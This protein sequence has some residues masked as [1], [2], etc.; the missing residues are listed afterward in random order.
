[1]W[2]FAF[3]ALF[4]IV[5][6]LGFDTAHIKFVAEG[7][8]QNDCFSTYTIIKL[9]LTSLMIVLSV[10]ALII[11]VCNGSMN[12][13]AVG[14]VAI[15]IMFCAVLDI[16]SIFITTFDARL[17]SGKN[18]I[19][20]IA[21][22]TI[23][24]ALLI[25][26]A[27]KQVSADVLST[28]YLV[29]IIVT[30]FLA[31]IL[32]KNVGL[33]LTRPTMFREYATFAAPL[34]L[35][36]LVLASIDSLDRVLIGFSGNPLEVGYYA[37]AM[38]AVVA[39]VSLGS[40]MNNVILPQL[41]S[42][43]MTGSKSKT[44]G[45][46]W[47]SQKY[48]MIMLLPMT[49]ILIVHGG[50]IASVLFGSD[51]HKAGLILSILSVMMT[52]KI[53]SGILSQVLYASNNVKLHTKASVIYG[54][55][56]ILMYFLFIPGYSP[57]PWSEGIGAALAIS[58]GSV[59]YILLLTYYVKQSA[60]VR[61]YSKMWKHIL[62]FSITITVMI[63]SLYCFEGAGLLW[64]AAMSLLGIGIHL[65]VLFITGEFRKSDVEFLLRAM[66]PKEIY[67]SL[68]DELH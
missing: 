67:E 28:S 44:E 56:V 25:I 23:R 45:L 68:E 36:S 12:A 29:S 11:S 18:S 10:T 40:S 6:G 41:S 51:F 58:I 38:G 60:G 33:K 53:M 46:V 17:E 31:F 64:V 27:L 55:L 63:L 59:V 8:N 5:A 20:I 26:L 9:L 2:G 39:V 22:S 30:I 42:P 13:E 14:V 3:V 61:V 66:N 24:S 21:E 43:E 1:M 34:I 19:I 15:F 62:A 7:R 47:T 4:N 52:L 32:T 37:A 57:F 65:G 49:A 54:L 50:E 35:S 48:L 16:R